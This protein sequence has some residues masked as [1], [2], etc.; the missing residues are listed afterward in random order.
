MRRLARVAAASVCAGAV[1]LAA[2]GCM[3]I[4][5][6][7]D[8]EDANPHKADERLRQVQKEQMTRMGNNPNISPAEYDAINSRLGN[9]GGLP[10]R[11]ASPEDLEK[12]LEAQERERR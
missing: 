3:L 1:S 11:P 4:P 5:I 7:A 9:P 10:P 12:R 8:D 2:G 6:L